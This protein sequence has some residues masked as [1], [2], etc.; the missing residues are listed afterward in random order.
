MG[1][2]SGYEYFMNMIDK[3]NEASAVFS[4][5]ALD[6][7]RTKVKREDLPLRGTLAQEKGAQLPPE[8]HG[9]VSPLPV[10]VSSA[11]GKAE[12]TVPD[13][14]LSARARA[15]STKSVSSTHQSTPTVPTAVTT[16]T[17]KLQAARS[18]PIRVTLTDPAL[19]IS[20]LARSLGEPQKPASTVEMGAPVG[21]GK[22]TKAYGDAQQALSVKGEGFDEKA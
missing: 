21:A 4:S 18:V 2:L 13:F 1:A 5:K 14:V 7:A 12:E 17:G 19:N 20:E 15:E 10:S 6:L 22:R 9:K 16:G 11:R 8:G 3:S